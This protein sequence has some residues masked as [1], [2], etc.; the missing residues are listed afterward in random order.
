MR[1]IN[2]GCGKITLPCPRPDHHFLIPEDLYTNPDITWDNADWNEAEGV[3]LIVDLFD[4]PWRTRAGTLEEVTTANGSYL[5]PPTEQPIPSNTYDVAIASHIAEHIPHHIVERGQFVARHPLYQ[6]GWFAWF[7]EL[8]RILKPG[9][10][11]YVLV[12]YAWSNAGIS[13]PTHTRYLTPASFGYFESG[14]NGSP[15]AY[16]TGA[17]WRLSLD[18]VPIRPHVRA[19]EHLRL[20]QGVSQ[21]DYSDGDYREIWTMGQEELNAIVEFLIVL[22]AVK[23]APADHV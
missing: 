7:A 14:E 16:R 18:V 12:P 20:R 17:Q 2:L 4:Y 8:W 6:D 1:G 11:A 15:F 9:G 13:D 23:D 3:N 5:V 19:V 21:L 10:K 22:E